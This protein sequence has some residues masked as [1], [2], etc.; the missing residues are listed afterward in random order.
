[1]INITYLPAIDPFHAVFR[2]FVL[3][4]TET[5]VPCP[6]EVARLLDFYICFPA[7]INDFKSPRDIIKQYNLLKKRYKE[8]SYQ[9]T[10]KPAVIFRRMQASQSAALSS[11]LS[12]GF[13]D[14]E[15]FQEGRIAR[16]TKEV[17]KRICAEVE[18][19]RGTNEELIA[20][21]EELKTRNPY[22]PDGLRARSKLEEYRYD[23]V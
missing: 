19:H 1:M 2:M 12:Y 21:L 4:P 20:Y 23:D 6:V 10:P 16:T 9:V 14:R 17:P 7:L 8:N 11:L 18:R 15:T 13:L 5:A 22:G 3:F